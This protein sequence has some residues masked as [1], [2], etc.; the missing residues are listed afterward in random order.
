MQPTQALCLGIAT[1]G[2]FRVE[3]PCRVGSQNTC[4][5]LGRKPLNVFGDTHI[6]G[7]GVNNAK[8]EDA[9]KLNFPTALT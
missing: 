4:R 1:G 8:L 3:N 6:D 5:N 9:A 2:A 7:S